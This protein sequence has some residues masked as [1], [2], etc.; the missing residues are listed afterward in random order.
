MALYLG[1]DGGGT[2]TTCVVADETVVLG[3]ATSGGS[4]VTRHGDARAREALHAGVKA[5]CAS[6]RIEPGQIESACAGLSGAGRPEVRTGAMLMGKR[7]AR[8]AGGWRFPTKD[9]VSG[10]VGG[11]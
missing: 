4:N 5:A 2:K 1:I 8:E 10:W 11:Q 7:R 3:S 6:A 9:P